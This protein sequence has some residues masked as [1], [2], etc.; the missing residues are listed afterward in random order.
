MH[1]SEGADDRASVT[2][3][4][5]EGGASPW[6]RCHKGCLALHVAARHGGTNAARALVSEAPDALFYRTWQEE[7]PLFLAAYEGRWR[8]ASYLLSVAQLYGK[9]FSSRSTKECPLMAAVVQ[10][11]LRGRSEDDLQPRQRGPS[12]N[13]RKVIDVLLD[14]GRGVFQRKDLVSSSVRCAAIL[15]GRADILEQLLD[16]DGEERRTQWARSSFRCRSMLHYAAGF[17]RLPCVDVLLRAGADEKAVDGQ[18]RQPNDL[19]GSLT[20]D[21]EAALSPGISDFSKANKDPA[22]ISAID[23][24]LERGPAYRARSWAYPAFGEA[25]IAAPD[26]NWAACSEETPEKNVSPLHVR[27]FR[28]QGS[29]RLP[30]KSFAAAVNRCVCVCGGERGRHRGRYYTIRFG[31]IIA[32]SSIPLTNAVCLKF[33]CTVRG[34]P[35]Y[36]CCRQ[37]PTVLAAMLHRSRRVDSAAIHIAVLT[38][39]DS[40]CQFPSRSWEMLSSRRRPVV[41]KQSDQ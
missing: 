38:V 32:S 16:V 21:S 17:A 35:A 39:A 13:Y 12:Q 28:R 18:L 36:I 31:H 20:I 34:T 7:T 14:S 25:R 3:M 5:L 10:A 1:A 11:C 8:T 30:T 6:G 9:G 22:T 2:H 40:V 19:L 37:L 15:G 27:I 41:L 23:R 29:T 4:L 24:M 33:A 26:Q